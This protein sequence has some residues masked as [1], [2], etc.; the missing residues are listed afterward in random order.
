M[1]DST[2]GMNLK[3]FIEKFTFWFSLGFL[4]WFIGAVLCV[5]TQILFSKAKKVKFPTIAAGIFI[6]FGLICFPYLMYDWTKAEITDNGDYHYKV[7]GNKVIFKPGFLRG[8]TD[9]PLPI[10]ITVRYEEEEE[11]VLAKRES[12]NDVF[13][14]ISGRS[15]G[16][17]GERIRVYPVKIP[18]VIQP[19]TIGSGGPYYKPKGY[20][21]WSLLIFQCSAMVILGYLGYLAWVGTCFNHEDNK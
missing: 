21:R 8:P 1:D 7:E 2:D 9:G 17:G 6:G 15:I 13:S 5:V 14:F 10:K 18:N 4:V 11:A 3:R 12:G 19:S 16:R 20:R